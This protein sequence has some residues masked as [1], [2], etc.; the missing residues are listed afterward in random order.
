[1]R[2]RTDEDIK[3]SSAHQES[4]F[5]TCPKFS[6]DRPVTRA[7][8]LAYV[9]HYYQNVW[10]EID[11]I[12]HAKRLW[13]G[14]YVYAVNIQGWTKPP[15]WTGGIVHHLARP[16]PG[17]TFTSTNSGAHYEIATRLRKIQESNDLDR[18]AA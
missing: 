13:V 7:E 8:A 17:V 1:M 9:H 4:L 6:F 5:A 14:N 18:S 12:A 11:A 15:D 16:V 10:T 2:S 3:R